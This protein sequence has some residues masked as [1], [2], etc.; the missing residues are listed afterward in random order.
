[1]HII[2]FLFLSFLVPSHAHTYLNRSEI[3]G[4]LHTILL[5]G[6][7]AVSRLSIDNAP[8]FNNW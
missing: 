3:S 2:C 6:N 4:S 7:G 8:A 1:M 5:L